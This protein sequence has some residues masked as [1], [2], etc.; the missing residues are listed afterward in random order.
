G[1]LREEF[2]QLYPALF[3]NAELHIRIIR[4]LAS[5]WQGLT[6]KEIVE[7]GKFSDGGNI[8]KTLEELVQSDFIQAFYHFGKKKK[9]IH[10][11]LM[12]EYSIFYLKF[13]ED[14]RLEEVGMWE[15][16][17]QTQTFKIWTGYAFENICLRHIPQIKKVLGISGVYSE[18]STYRSQANDEVAGAQIDFLIDR[19]DHIINLFE[20]KFHNTEFIVKQS[21]ASALRKK[22]GIFQH[23]TNTKKL[24][25]WVLITTF[26]LE[27]NKHNIGLIDHVIT[28]DALF[29]KV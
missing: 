14:Q 12:D 3:D 24:L 11:R 13:I 16:F 28:M 22:M 9:G 5:T 20:V 29:E 18:T 1:F 17:S 26:G 10:Y 4:L 7:K 23:N 2:N 21:Y 6:R 25:S 19:N 15:K 27:K 8:S